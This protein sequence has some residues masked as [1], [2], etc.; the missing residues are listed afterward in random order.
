MVIPE[1]SERLRTYFHCFTPQMLPNKWNW[2]RLKPGTRNSIT[3]PNMNGRKQLTTTWYLTGMLADNHIQRRTE[4]RP[5]FT[6]PW[7]VSI[8]TSG[9]LNMAC[10]TAVPSI[11][12]LG[13]CYSLRKKKTKNTDT[14]KRSLL[15]FKL[16]VDIVIERSATI[17]S[18]C[19]HIRHSVNFCSMQCSKIHSNFLSISLMSNKHQLMIPIPSLPA[20]TIYGER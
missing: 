2:I 11:L 18:M 4:V 8:P 6:S 13:K 7:L 17:L 3:C 9:L 5:H 16:K 12:P 10:F 14:L 19:I 1:S 20:H 15:C